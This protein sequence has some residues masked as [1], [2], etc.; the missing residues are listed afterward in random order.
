MLL[1]GTGRKAKRGTDVWISLPELHHVDVRDDPKALAERRPPCVQ[2]FE[3]FMSVLGRPS[4]STTDPQ[5]VE[6]G[7]EGQ[8]ILGVLIFRPGIHSDLQEHPGDRPLN[9]CRGRSWPQWKTMSPQN[10]HSV[11]FNKPLVLALD[12][13]NKLRI[14]L[15]QPF[16]QRDEHLST[17][18]FDPFANRSSLRLGEVVFQRL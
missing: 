17:V 12:V 5:I 16:E 4:G 10:G 1:I 11:L 14:L 18:R 6:H 13:F 9:A 15:H 3:P 8:G 2:P 7:G